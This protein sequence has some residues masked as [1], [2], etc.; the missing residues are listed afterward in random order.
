MLDD[1]SMPLT[2]MTYRALAEAARGAAQGL[3]ERDVMP[4]VRI[5]LMLPTGRDFFIAFFAIL[6]AGAC[7]SRSI[8]QCGCPSS[9][10]ICAVRR[11]SCATLAP[12]S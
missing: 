12:V 10:S 8:R 5:A 3:I 11:P 2:A 6:Y 9:R 1:E 4:G 7:Q